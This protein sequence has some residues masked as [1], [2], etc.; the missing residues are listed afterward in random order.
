MDCLR[1]ADI[2][3]LSVPLTSETTHLIADD[4]LSSMKD[5]AL[6]INISRGGV[7]DTV[8]LMKHL[9]RLFG[10]ALDVFEEEPLKPDNPLWNH[11][12]VLI[13]P[14]NSFVGDG[15]ADRLTKAILENLQNQ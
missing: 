12:N 13:T 7:L 15:N 3:V 8:S 6:L 4:E 11:E 1:Q 5:E 10:A 2:V 9:P 14:H